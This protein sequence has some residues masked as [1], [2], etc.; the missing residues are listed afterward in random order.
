MI[1]LEPM[2]DVA[3]GLLVMAGALVT[4][5]LLVRYVRTYREE[6]TRWAY[7]A[8]VMLATVEAVW[9]GSAATLAGRLHLIDAEIAQW[10][11]FGSRLTL[12]VMVI[13]LYL[14]PHIPDNHK[15]STARAQ[16]VL[17]G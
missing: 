15:G 8:V 17:D 7:R 1:A 16:E 12:L 2:F 11:A 10:V 3:S 4:L 13:W 14:L 9:L 6:H 5:L